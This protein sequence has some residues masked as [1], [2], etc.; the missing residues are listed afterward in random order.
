MN[1]GANINEACRRLSWSWK[2]CPDSRAYERRIA[3]N[4]GVTLPTVSMGFRTS[5]FTDHLT[6]DEI[7][8]CSSLSPDCG[9][10]HISPNDFPVCSSMEPFFRKS[11]LSA[12]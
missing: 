11:T 9:K 10:S 12:E 4:A 8:V 2:S 3:T 1:A 5:I 7:G 6:N